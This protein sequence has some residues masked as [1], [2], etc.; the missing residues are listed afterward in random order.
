MKSDNFTFQR[1]VENSEERLILRIIVNLRVKICLGNVS[2]IVY[3]QFYI[4]LPVYT[5]SSIL[6]SISEKFPGLHYYYMRQK[7][8]Q[9]FLHRGMVNKMGILL[10]RAKVVLTVLQGLKRIIQILDSEKSDSF[11]QNEEDI[12]RKEIHSTNVY[13][14]TINVLNQRFR[15]E[16][17]M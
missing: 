2:C 14:A 9:C 13:L 4:F 5:L 1:M 3:L 17:C 6:F 7:A 16:L 15:D 11:P 12:Q 8:S 10:P